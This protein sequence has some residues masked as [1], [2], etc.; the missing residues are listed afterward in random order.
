MRRINKTVILDT[1][2]A[3]MTTSYKDRMLLDALEQSYHAAGMTWNQDAVTAIGEII[4]KSVGEGFVLLKDLDKGVQLADPDLVNTEKKFKEK[5][6]VPCIKRKNEQKSYIQQTL[7]T[8]RQVGPSLAE[9]KERVRDLRANST[10]GDDDCIP[11]RS[12]PAVSAPVQKAVKFMTFLKRVEDWKRRFVKE[13]HKFEV[14]PR[15]SGEIMQSGSVGIYLA[16]L[17]RSDFGTKNLIV[18][19]HMLGL[20]T[21]AISLTVYCASRKCCKERRSTWMRPVYALLHCLCE[22]AGPATPPPPRHE[23]SAPPDQN[24]AIQAIDM[25]QYNNVPTRPPRA[26]MYRPDSSGNYAGLVIN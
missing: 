25:Q 19:L 2:I 15:G 21:M 17:W 16:Q 1:R 4:K 20:F 8:F 24:Q 7:E 22:K 12:E 18:V 6:F 14:A 11:V 26:I 3:K 10:D 5:V 13:L 9:L 23:Y